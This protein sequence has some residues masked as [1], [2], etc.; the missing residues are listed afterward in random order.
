MTTL[1]DHF[2]PLG[3]TIEAGPVVLRSITDELLAD[4]CEVAARG[5]HDPS[6]MPF[7][8]PWTDVPAEDFAPSFLAY[9]W[10][11]R[12]EFSRE[13]W[14]LNLAVLHEGELVGVQ[15]IDTSHY[16][17]TRTGET[18]SWLGREFHGRGIGTA[19]RQVMCAFVFDHL[20]AAEIASGAFVDN[21]A[22]LAVSRK[23]G[24]RP[25]G[26]RRLKR[27]EGELALNQ[28]LVLSPDDFVRGPHPVQVSGV[29][30]FRAFIGLDAVA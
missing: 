17:V 8:F 23:V 10:R 18:G 24:Y 4:L 3:L 29:E 5:V 2:P 11:T 15:G 28:S 6:E 7:Y 16:L 22:S 19:M 20:D 12:A 25:N 30:A 21:P 14:S 9:H 26:V 13:S 27:R 1:A